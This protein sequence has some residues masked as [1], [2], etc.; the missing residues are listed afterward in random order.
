MPGLTEEIQD[1]IMTTV[2]FACTSPSLQLALYLGDFTSAFGTKLLVDYS[3]FSVVRLDA[4]LRSCS[5]G[6]YIRCSSDISA[7]HCR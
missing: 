5:S 1:D 3:T 4:V 7:S 2:C 6:S